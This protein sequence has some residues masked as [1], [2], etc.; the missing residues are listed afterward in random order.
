[1]F[2]VAAKATVSFRVG[3]LLLL[4]WFAALTT[5]DERKRKDYILE[6][7]GHDHK[8]AALFETVRILSHRGLISC[9]YSIEVSCLVFFWT[10]TGILSIRYATFLLLRNHP[11]HPK[12]VLNILHLS[13]IQVSRLN[14]IPIEC[15]LHF[16]FPLLPNILTTRSFSILPL[17]FLIPV[18]DQRLL[19]VLASALDSH[20]EP[21]LRPMIRTVFQTAVTVDVVDLAADGGAVKCFV[22]GLTAGHRFGE[23]G[24]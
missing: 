23:G 11:N 12:R 9:I 19:G 8:I 20:A 14:R 17:L 21:K 10:N 16:H 2:F 1:M 7:N 4:L 5:I 3:V 15:S 6:G 18:P 13:P 24:Y 22:E